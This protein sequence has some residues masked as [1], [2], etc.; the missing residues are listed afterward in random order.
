MP[1]FPVRELATALLLAALAAGCGGTPSGAVEPQ[2]QPGDLALDYITAKNYTSLKIV[3]DYIQGYGPSLEALDRARAI[4]EKR[5][6]KPGGVEFVINNEIPAS[7]GRALW[8]IG[9]IMALESQFRKAFTGDAQNPHTAV[10]WMVYLNGGSEFDSGTARALGV[11]Y[12][13]AE[14]AIFRESIDRVATTAT[15]DVVEGM[16]LVHEGGHLF[17]LVNNGLPMVNNHED[18]QS[19]RHDAS[20]DCVMFHEIETSDVARLLSNP[21]IDYDL[22]CRLD[23]FAAGDSADPPQGEPEPAPEPLSAPNRT[24]G[25]RGPIPDMARIPAGR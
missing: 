5:L 23:M 8:Q 22:Q 11:S 16:V 17:G 9:D 18:P 15:R 2:A 4:W 21:P 20:P 19:A 3:V 10:I 12:G 7:Q 25:G 6:E 24:G 1:R 14:T 13:G